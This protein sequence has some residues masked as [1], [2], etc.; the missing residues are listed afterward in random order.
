MYQNKGFTLIELLVVVLII[1]ILAAVALP[2]YQVAVAKSQYV[3]AMTLFN[4]IYRAQQVYFLANG[5]YAKDVADLD[6][7]LPADMLPKTS[8]NDMAWE[9][10]EYLFYIR[11]NDTEPVYMLI[12]LKKYAQGSADFAPR[13][14]RYFSQKNSFCYVPSSSSLWNTVCKS[15]GGE[16][17]SSDKMWSIYALKE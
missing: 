10:N 17:T 11:M 12:A 1:G 4:T 5:T 9:N 16:R 8:G 2:Q 14:Q 6:V 15:L 7:T 3:K 13:Y